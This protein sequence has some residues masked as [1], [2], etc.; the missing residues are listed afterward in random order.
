MQRFLPRNKL[1]VELKKNLPTHELLQSLGFIRQPRAGIVNWLPL[2]L[3]SLRKVEDIIRNEMNRIGGLEASLSCISSKENWKISG[4]WNNKE[5]FKFQ[6]LK[7]SEYC[8]TP[9]CE[10]D[11]TALIK[12]YIRSYKDLA[13]NDLLVYQIGKKYRDELRPRGG[14]LRGREFLMKDAYSFSLDQEKSIKVFERLNDSYIR[15]FNQLKLPFLIAWADSGNIGGELSKEYHYECKEGEDTLF[16]CDG[17]HNVTNLEK[18]E[19]YPSFKFIQEVPDDQIVDVTYAL[20]SDHDGI[21]CYYYPKGRTLNWNL[22]KEAVEDDIDTSLIGKSNDFIIKKFS[23]E[24]SEEL[25]FSRITRVMD[26]RINSRNEFPDFPIKQYLKNNFSTIDNGITIVDAIE[27]EMCSKCY[28]GSLKSVKSVEVGHIFNIGEKYSKAFGLNYVDKSDKKD[29]LVSMGCYGIGI[30][31]ILGVIAE[32]GR[33]SKGLRWPSTI[34][35]YKI[36]IVGKRSMDEN[37][38]KVFPILKQ[39]FNDDVFNIYDMDK[40]MSWKYGLN[41]QL[42]LSNAIGIPISVVVGEKTQLPN[43]EI[44]IRGIN[45]NSNAGDEIIH[46]KIL[47]IE[48]LSED[49]KAI[50]N[51]I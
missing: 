39:T 9:T 35:P 4:R 38:A 32:I 5:M 44:E 13:Q 34:A 46:K 41:G 33:D 11:I 6:D 10:E 36:S 26:S 43:I 27:N 19:S 21:I 18:T 16:I 17:C 45:W 8:L 28:D 37:V 47:N 48:T 3:R 49:L 12:P 20:N 23:E 1:S 31:R 29:N 15:I 24:N 40:S 42:E 2:G 25:M 51:E 14:L 7:K 50:L 22:A 30:S